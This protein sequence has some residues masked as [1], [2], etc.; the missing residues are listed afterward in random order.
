MKK[1]PLFALVFSFVILIVACQRKEDTP[2]QTSI[3]IGVIDSTSLL[4]SDQKNDLERWIQKLEKETGS[5]IA[6]VIVDTL[7][8]KN[9]NQ[10]S[11][12][13]AENLNLGREKY[14]D[15]LL[16]FVVYKDRKI[17]IEVGYGLE[18]VIR[19]EIASRIIREKMAPKFK[20][21]EYYEGLLS[22]VKEIS[23]LIKANK[24]LIGA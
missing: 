19:N 10:V 5:Q 3:R 16:I 9:I 12:T 24:P 7:G 2:A 18:R 21:Q 13:M 4:S 23:E 20:K 17:R 8:V 22:A 15:G 11:L 6:I 1:L 14:R